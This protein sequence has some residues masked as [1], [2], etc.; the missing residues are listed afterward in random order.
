VRT[1]LA[2]SKVN[3]CLYLGESR[4]ADGRHALVTVFDAVTL[5]DLLVVEFGVESDE[6]I[7]PGVEGPNLVSDA[8]EA[9]RDAG[10][11]EP[12]VRVIIEKRIPVAAGMGGGSADAAA[13]LALARTPQGS[14]DVLAIAQRLGADVAAMIDP[15]VWMATGAGDELMQIRPQLA[16][17]AYLVL[18]SEFGLSTADVY[19]EADRLGSARLAD[20]LVDRERAVRR[21]LGD[22]GRFPAELIVN[23]LQPAA[24]SLCPSIADAL[25][26][27]LEAGADE[28][29]VSGSGPTAVGIWWGERCLEGAE[30]AAT[31]LNERGGGAQIALPFASPSQ[32]G[33]TG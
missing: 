1:I 3:L 16:P 5:A 25:N 26:A 29:I 13:V 20:E 24:L 2:P 10:W 28:A 14:I 30:R 33:P 32:F 18:A 23:D 7:C 6:V 27:L 19:R 15:G 9:L 31:A 11:D 4:P 17:H 12:P 8:L 21:A 22:G